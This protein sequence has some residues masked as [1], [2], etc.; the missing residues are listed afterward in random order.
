MR[1]VFGSVIGNGVRIEALANVEFSVL[2]DDSVV[3]RQAMVKFSVLDQRASVGGVIQMGVMGEAAS[4]KRGAYLLDMNFSGDAKIS[5][6]GE[7]RDAPLSLIGCC[8]GAE[9]MV[10]LG[11]QIAAGRWVPPN[12]KIVADPDSILQKISAEEDGLYCVSKG[13]LKQI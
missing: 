10:G 13:A 4:L 2:S 9:S 1:V 11:V 7:L 12:R 3:Q 8:I 5:W 6:D